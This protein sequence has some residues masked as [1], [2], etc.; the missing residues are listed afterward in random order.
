MVGLHLWPFHSLSGCNTQ[1]H[2]KAHLCAP[3][4]KQGPPK[5]SSGSRGVRTHTPSKVTNHQAQEASTQQICT[6]FQN[7]FSIL[8]RRQ[9]P[10]FPSLFFSL[11]NQREAQIKEIH[12][13]FR[14]KE[15]PGRLSCS[16]P[17]LDPRSSLVPP[18][19]RSEHRPDVVPATVTLP[20]NT[21][22]RG[23]P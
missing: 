13:A 12:K 17:G 6:C 7:L 15:V 8:D 16:Q 2:Q 11:L 1:A 19:S 3:P 20:N 10:F 4:W 14:R 23:P 9:N 18:Q 5:A 22:A 21:T